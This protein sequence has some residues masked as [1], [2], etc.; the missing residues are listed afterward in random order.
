MNEYLRMLATTVA[1]RPDVDAN[2]DHY[3]REEVEKQYSASKSQ[4]NWMV[5]LLC[6][7]CT[8]LGFFIESAIQFGSLESL[9]L[10]LEEKD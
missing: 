8:L 10:K 6:L 9:E 1:S 3:F 7:T 4:T 5:L 2:D